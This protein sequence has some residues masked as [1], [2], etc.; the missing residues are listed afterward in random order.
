MELRCQR[1]HLGERIERIAETNRAGQLEKAVEE[2]IRD[3]FLD[4]E[5]RAG[6]ACL[7]L[8][9]KNCECASDD[10]RIEIRIVKDNIR[11]FAAEFELHTLSSFQTRAC[12][13]LRP[14]TV[15]P[16]KAILCTP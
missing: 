2:S 8:I 1:S 6:D 3:F 13:I 15:D 5:T 16:V 7:P 14:V 4:Q 12:T 10:G 11:T 9:V